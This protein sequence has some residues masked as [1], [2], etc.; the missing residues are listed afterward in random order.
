MSIF[1][2]TALMAPS[3]SA[4]GM[5]YLVLSQDESIRDLAGVSVRRGEATESVAKGR[6]Y[7][8]QYAPPTPLPSAPS[9]PS[10]QP[11]DAGLAAPPGQTQ[12]VRQATIVPFISVSERYDSNVLFSTDKVHDYVTNI[13]PG[14]RWNFQNNL[15]NG[16]LTGTMIAERYVLNPGLSYIGTSGGLNVGLDNIFGNVIRGWSVQVSDSYMYTPQ[17]PAFVAPDTGNQVPSSF[18]RGI[19]AF[20]ANSLSNVG[21]VTSTVP[22]TQVTSFA[23]TYTHQILRFFSKADPS[24]AGALFNVTNQSL[25]A[26]PQYRISP[27]HSVGLTYQYQ[28]MAFTDPAGGTAP[29]GITTHGGMLTW[30]GRLSPLINVELGGGGSVIQPTNT[31][32][33]TGRAL[34]QYTTPALTSS[35]SYSRAIAPSYYLASGALISDLVAFSTTYNISSSWFLTAAYNYS[36]SHVTAGPAINFKSHGPMGSVNYRINRYIVASGQ[37][38]YYQMTFGSTGPE[39][40]VNRETITLSVRGEWN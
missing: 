17:Q 1:L 22:L 20:R 39:S 38:N 29:A 8:T 28:D 25:S 40:A 7:Q 19:Q 13:S 4:G 37:F 24:L 32:Q 5:R 35:L 3:S 36:T 31:F 15:I 14:A 30:L 16:S 12:P 33:H 27:N 10:G 18:I 9:S 2:L 11:P 21:A 34:V 23:T 26:G 6:V